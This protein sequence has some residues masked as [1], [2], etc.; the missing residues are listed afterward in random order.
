MWISKKEYEEHG[1]GIVEKK[2]P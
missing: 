2:C 1:K